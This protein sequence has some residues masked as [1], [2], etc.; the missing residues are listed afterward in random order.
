MVLD[1]GLAPDYV[2]DKIES[3]EIESLM[4][5]SYYR[6]KE[7]WEQARLISYLTTQTHSSKKLKL[8][9]IIKFSWEKETPKDTHI[10]NEDIAR[11]SKQAEEMEK[12]F[13]QQQ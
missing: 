4:S 2:L 10:S 12:L 13:T 3:Y 11:L 5:H 7:S 9:D 8:Q 6:H 1:F